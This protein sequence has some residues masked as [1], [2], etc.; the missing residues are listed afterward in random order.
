M[1]RIFVK[2]RVFIIN[3]TEKISII[4]PIYNTGKYL[5]RCVD[6]V[7]AQTYQNIEV[8]LVNDGSTDESSNICEWY[9]KQDKRVKVIHKKGGHLVECGLENH[10]II[11]VLL[12]VI[13]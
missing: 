8:I 4:I 9:K 2:E 12:I 6:S 13:G 10:R 1:R 11:L 7:L 5:K 3:N